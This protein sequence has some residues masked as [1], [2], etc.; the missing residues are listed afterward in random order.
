VSTILRLHN[1]TEHFCFT[2]LRLTVPVRMPHHSLRYFPHFSPFDYS[3]LSKQLE[4]QN[5]NIVWPSRPQPP[6]SPPPHPSNTQTTLSFSL[7]S[8]PS[9]TALCSSLL[10]HERAD[11]SLAINERQLTAR[12]GLV[13]VNLKRVEASSRCEL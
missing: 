8:K 11:G 3:Y 2:I 13:V 5:S 4:Q 10:Q 6:Y 1:L 12:Y 9:I 7:P